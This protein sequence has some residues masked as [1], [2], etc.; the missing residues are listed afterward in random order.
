VRT[1]ARG[2]DGQVSYPVRADVGTAAWIDC[3]GHLPW[4][5]SGDQRL[6][7]AASLTWTWDAEGLQ[8]LGHPVVRLRLSADA[9]SASVSVKLCDVFP[10]GTSALVTRGSLVLEMDDPGVERPVE[11]TLDACAY[12]FAA[13]QH[14]RLSV[15]GADW[16][17]TVAPPRPLAVTVH[18]GE[19]DLP[20]WSGNTPYPP[21]VLAPGADRSG[22]DPT[23]AVWRVE[24]DVLAR[25]TA[26]VVDHGTSYDVP[27]GGKATEHYAGR[28]EVDTRTFEQRAH[29]DVRYELAWP[30]ISASTRST[31]DLTVSAESYDVDIWLEARDGEQVLGERRWSRRLPR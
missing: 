30:G 13:G 3:A 16:P 26:C 7:D 11:V 17:N 31:L 18:G 4:G 12:A 1:T 25:T 14:L 15:A 24:R 19:L 28:V 9:P 8:L 6:D 5:L 23:A 29:A 21:P 22:E 2:I 10:D 27:Y 20:V